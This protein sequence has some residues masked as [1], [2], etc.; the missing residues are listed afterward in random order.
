MKE[1]L[2]H[3]GHRERLKN[4]FLSSGLDS[5]EAHNILELL[6]FYSIPRQDTNEIA[7]ALIQRFGSVKG[8][9]DADF[10]ELIKVKGIKENSATLIKLIPQLAKAYMTED[11]T[12][13]QKLIFDSIDKVGSYLVKKFIGETKEV[14]YLML[15][16]NKFKLIKIEKIFEGSVNSSAIDARKIVE[17]VF[18]N[19]ASSIILA[20]NHPNGIHLPS[21]EDIETTG[22]FASI[23][24]SIGVTILEHFIVAGTQYYPVMTEHG[25]LDRN[26]PRL[27][28][29]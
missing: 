24:P 14:V 27:I 16:D 15:L 1:K 12:D 6:L 2:P 5:F 8:V 26:A 18:S 17:K 28:R 10:S 22:M 11:G 13:D 25:L 19:N 21:M 3:E 23:L 7:H 4:R 9:F 20:H 29:D